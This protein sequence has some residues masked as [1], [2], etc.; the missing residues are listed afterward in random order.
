MSV[1]GGR[2]VVVTGGGR[3]I[4]AAIAS[5]FADLGDTVVAVDLGADAHPDPRVETVTADVA[6]APEVTAAFDRIVADHGGV[7]VLVNNAGVWFVRPFAEITVE[8]WDRVLGVNLRG[9]FLCTRAA[10]ASMESRGGGVVVNVGSQA[11]ITVTRGQGAHYHA[12]KA[13]VTHLTKV[14][15]FELGPLG[16]RVNCVAPG[17]TP[18]DPSLFP[19]RLLDQIPVGRVGTPADMAAAVVFL[20]S[21]DAAFVDGQTLL[22]NGGAV[23][24]L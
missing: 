21:D 12:S 16:I 19:G 2:V 9:V 10:L 20:A 17:A 15:A 8:E 11:G 5:R 13:A 14:L 24:F 6:A 23:A 18:A 7:D 4:G 3:G 22:V 1:A